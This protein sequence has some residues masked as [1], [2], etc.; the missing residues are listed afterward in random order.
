MQQ[1]QPQTLPT[2]QSNMIRK[3]QSQKSETSPQEATQPAGQVETG[4]AI[5]KDFEDEFTKAARMKKE[6]MERTAAE[7][8]KRSEATERA[9]GQAN[10]ALSGIDRKMADEKEMEDLAKITKEDIDLAEKLIFNGYAEKDVSMTNFPDRKF[11]I[12]TTTPEEVNLVEEMVFE[13]IKSF[14]NAK[15][16]DVDL[17]QS[18]VQSYR[19]A[20]SLAT[21]YKGMDGKDFCEQSI[22]QL[23]L[24]KRAVAACRKYEF[25][26][27]IQKAKDTRKE[28]KDSMKY[29]AARIMAMSTQLIDFLNMMKFDFD[30]AMYRIMTTKHLIPKS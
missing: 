22:Y 14:E 15:T 25:E 29:R 19:N 5:K 16:G 11:T 7:S 10:D 17:P 18:K 27:E 8:Q 9:I 28:L 26:G 20:L 23:Q 24:I 1:N 4:P 3:T 13:Y 21:S 30:N 2:A 12:T 6:V